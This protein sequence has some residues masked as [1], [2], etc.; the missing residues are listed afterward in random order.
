MEWSFESEPIVRR[1]SL[2]ETI[3][4]LTE[5]SSTPSLKSQ[6]SDLEGECKIVRFFLDTLSGEL[7]KTIEIEGSPTSAEMIFLLLEKYSPVLSTDISVCDDFQ[8][9]QLGQ[10]GDKILYPGDQPFSNSNNYPFG[11]TENFNFLLKD[12][13]KFDQKS[14]PSTLDSMLKFGNFLSGAYKSTPTS[15]SNFSLVS[16]MS[17]DSSSNTGGSTPML[18]TSKALLT[19][20]YPRK[21]S[22]PS[23]VNDE[24]KTNSL[25]RNKSY[26]KS[27]SAQIRKNSFGAFI[28]FK[29]KKKE[30]DD[31]FDV[32]NPIRKFS[33][34]PPAPIEEY[35]HPSLFIPIHICINKSA[36]KKDV[37]TNLPLTHDLT[38]DRALSKLLSMEGVNKNDHRLYGLYQVPTSKS[39]TL[40]RPER[41]RSLAW[42][43]DQAKRLDGRERLIALH[44]LSKS[45]PAIERRFELK[46]NSS[47]EPTANQGKTFNLT[48]R[49]VNFGEDFYNDVNNESPVENECILDPPNVLSTDSTVSPTQS[50]DTI[51]TEIEKPDISE[52]ASETSLASKEIREEELNNMLDLHRTPNT[53]PYLLNLRSYPIL[54]TLL[55]H[56]NDSVVYIG[57]DYQEGRLTDSSTFV[58]L[59]GSD[60]K[61][62]HCRISFSPPP[63]NIPQLIMHIEPIADAI[64]LVNNKPVAISTKV[65]P[66]DLI[67]LGDNFLFMYRNP[68]FE[69][70]YPSY[71]LNWTAHIN[72]TVPQS[73]VT[74]LHSTPKLIMGE[75]IIEKFCIDSISETDIQNMRSVSMYSDDGFYSVGTLSPNEK[76]TMLFSLPNFDYL[77]DAVTRKFEI[78][79]EKGKLI[80]ACMLAQGFDYSQKKEHSLAVNFFHS[81]SS[82]LTNAIKT[83][84]SKLS[85]IQAD[86]IFP[87]QALNVYESISKEFESALLWLNNGLEFVTYPNVYFSN[88]P[89]EEEGM[90]EEMKQDVSSLQKV[91]DNGVN[92]TMDFFLKLLRAPLAGLIDENHVQL[93]LSPSSTCTETSGYMS[94]SAS[95]ISRSSPTHKQHSTHNPNIDIVND[96]LQVFYKTLHD[97]Y[98]STELIPEIF[99]N[100]F[101]RI[102]KYLSSFIFEYGEELGLYS[103][104]RGVQMKNCVAEI[105]QWA[106]RTG[107]MQEYDTPASSLDSIL[108]LLS[109]GCDELVKMEWNRLRKNYPLLSPPQLHHILLHYNLPGI[110]GLSGLPGSTSYDLMPPI[111]L[112]IT[113]EH[114][115]PS[116]T[117]ADSAF[118]NSQIKERGYL[119]P[120]FIFPSQPYILMPDKV[121]SDIPFE[122]YVDKLYASLKDKPPTSPESYDSSSNTV[123]PMQDLDN[124]SSQDE[125]V[126]E[127]RFSSFDN[128]IGCSDFESSLSNMMCRRNSVDF[129]LSSGDNDFLT[130]F[131]NERFCFTPEHTLNG[132]FSSTLLDRPKSLDCLHRHTKSDTINYDN[133]FG[134]SDIP[135]SRYEVGFTQSPSTP[136]K[137]SSLEHHQL[138]ISHSPPVNVKNKESDLLDLLGSPDVSSESEGGDVTPK[139]KRK[140]FVTTLSF[141]IKPFLTPPLLSHTVNLTDEDSSKSDDETPI[142]SRYPHIGSTPVSRIREINI[143]KD[144]DKPIGLELVRG[145]KTEENIPGIYIKSIAR[146][147]SASGNSQLTIGSKILSINHTP[148]NPT[149]LNNAKE[150]ISSSEENILFR[151]LPCDRHFIN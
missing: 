100:L 104:T 103:H 23:I 96:L 112:V 145:D 132:I 83:S 65:N 55:I 81:A 85:H 48:Y 109:T 110:P 10:D 105:E 31:D 99:T 74:Q 51:T 80:P 116:I 68:A 8:L 49:A 119:P 19:P 77:I 57:S 38:V 140:P 120:P 117:E 123:S 24:L 90:C 139:T 25:N 30:I 131:E 107:L 20:N 16:N 7:M 111:S 61:P 94:S 115:R 59:K 26:S 138:K 62:T 63:P 70:H 13:R 91:I 40:S 21:S 82:A 128:I 28:R 113:P 88:Q 76:K 41:P 64:V 144:I 127:R 126:T 130:D 122:Q 6:Y 50:T 3:I 60:I 136:H 89:S 12:K 17:S 72:D 97:T 146:D 32:P 84:V 98:T 86:Y 141:E 52:Y 36:Q 73:D 15:S 1:H 54:T 53:H 14:N 46:K 108:R 95:N 33:T 4:P 45:S 135:V 22:L 151:V 134:I 39:D 58:S 148:L 137:S 67:Q 69:H 35:E 147:S 79:S 2:Q 66:G 56:L 129:L 75:S 42:A 114:W 102:K 106:I 87:S 78:Y 93:S 47:V 43:D 143:I 44:T 125:F 11:S 92:E 29:G 124:D 71:R 9:I 101:A 142:N 18:D 118:N 5:H 34:M 133:V 37:V 149:D 27:K 150:L 121:S